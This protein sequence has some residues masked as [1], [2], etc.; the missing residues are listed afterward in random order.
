[1]TVSILAIPLLALHILRYTNQSSYSKY[2]PIKKYPKYASSV[3]LSLFHQQAYPNTKPVIRKR[4][5]QQ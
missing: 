1:M 3:S 2:L 4:I 5:A